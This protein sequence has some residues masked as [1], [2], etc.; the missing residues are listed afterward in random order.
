MG[1]NVPALR[2][3]NGDLRELTSGPEAEFLG[4]GVQSYSF[5]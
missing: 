5:G 2:E 3:I 1:E 4:W